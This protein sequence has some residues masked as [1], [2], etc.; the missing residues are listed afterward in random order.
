[1][2]NTIIFLLAIL[3]WTAELIEL[4]YVTGQVARKGIIPTLV[5]LYVAGEYIWDRLTS[6]N[7]N[8]KVYRTP[9]TTG[10]AYA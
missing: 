2:N 6:M 5:L 7:Y 4:T 8:I 3:D 10:Y 9:L 1:M